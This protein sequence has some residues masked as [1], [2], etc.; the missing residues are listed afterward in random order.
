MDKYEASMARLD[1][2]KDVQ[3][4]AQA[5]NIP[6]LNYERF[7]YLIGYKSQSARPGAFS[8]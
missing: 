2:Y 6:I 4:L 8:D 1:D 5:L 3:K 7:L